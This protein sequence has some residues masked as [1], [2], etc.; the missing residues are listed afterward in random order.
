M[1][2]E[3]KRTKRKRGGQKGNHNARKHGFYSSSLT[4][5]EIS[6]FWTLI[7]REHIDP[8]MAILRI[9]LQSMFSQA[10]ANSR[11]FKEIARLIVKWA[12]V[13]Y[14][15]NRSDRAYLRDG[16]LIILEGSSGISLGMLEKLCK[17]VTNYEK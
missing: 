14:H 10:P 13:K 2:S 11:T 9:K 12:A 7:S 8:E 15:L 5:D 16:V 17:I 4:P 3:M 6:E 1:T